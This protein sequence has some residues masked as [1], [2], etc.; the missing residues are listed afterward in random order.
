MQS[1]L[2][3]PFIQN[4]V[5]MLLGICIGVVPGFFLRK[6]IYFRERIFHIQYIQ[7]LER[8]LGIPQN[9]RRYSFSKWDGNNYYEDEEYIIILKGS[10]E[11]QR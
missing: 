4:V 9:L 11:D 2:A 3:D 10:E 8:K 1:L 6:R 5:C 7:F